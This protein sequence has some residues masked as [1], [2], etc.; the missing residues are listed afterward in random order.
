MVPTAPQ[1]WNFIIE[2]PEEYGV[3]NVIMVVDDNPGVGAGI[4]PL[5]FD[6]DIQRLMD[7]DEVDEED[8]EDLEDKDREDEDPDDSDDSDEESKE[9]GHDS[10]FDYEFD[11]DIQR[12]MDLDEVDEEDEEDDEDR[13]DEDREDE[14]RE[15]EDP[16]SLPVLAG[17][18]AGP[19]VLPGP[20][21][22]PSSP[23]F[24]PQCPEECAPSTSGLN[25]FLKR[26]REESSTEQ[27][28]RKRP[29][30]CGEENPED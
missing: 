29:R 30:T 21:A 7:L 23:P 10:M 5:E 19:P 14:D 28:S 26:S 3:P 8:E 20:S 4:P 11:E 16:A 24:I 12:L 2:P 22:G 6:K 25:F 27:V 1:V 9:S 18:S 13:E 15:D 17:P